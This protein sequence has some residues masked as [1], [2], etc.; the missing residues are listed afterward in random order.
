MPPS[1]T[2]HGGQYDTKHV[3]F[4][5]LSHAGFVADENWGDMLEPARNCAI[6]LMLC[7]LLACPFLDS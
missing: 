6:F 2:V 5:L 1:S 7:L 3:T 4:E